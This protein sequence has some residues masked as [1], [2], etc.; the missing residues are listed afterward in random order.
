MRARAAR[1]WPLAMRSLCYSAEGSC[2]LAAG[3]SKYVCLYSVDQRVLLKRFC[4]SENRS[5]EG[6][7]AKLNSKMDTE[8]G[9]LNVIDDDSASDVEDRIDGS[10]PGVAKVRAV[11]CPAQRGAVGGTL[12]CSD[13]ACAG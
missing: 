10:L 12:R 7:V 11:V 4:L 3:R 13:I 2:L 5:L 9:P 8:F 1:S 6:I